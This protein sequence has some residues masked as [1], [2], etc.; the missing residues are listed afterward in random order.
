MRRGTTQLNSLTS[1]RFFAAIAVVLHHGSISLAPGSVWSTIFSAGYVGVSFFFVLS[2]FVLAWSF[3]PNLPVGPFYGRRFARIYPLHIITA[4]ISVPVILY[5]GGSIVP[6]AALANVV[7]LQGWVPT[8]E[9]GSSLNGVSWSLSCEAFF[10]AMFPFVVRPLITSGHPAR[11]A[12][13]IVLAIIFFAIAA[14]LF[15]RNRLLSKSSTRILCFASANLPSA[16]CW[17][18]MFANFL[19]LIASLS[20]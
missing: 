18:R 1:L 13:A 15:F 2:G 4:A 17:L 5:C 12:A 8:E 19:A 20:R 3:D 16:Y 10:Y 7:L 9:Y 14:H 11:L 6:G